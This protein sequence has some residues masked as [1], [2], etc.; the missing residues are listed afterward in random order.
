MEKYPKLVHYFKSHFNARLV[1]LLLINGIVPVLLISLTTY[2]FWFRTM[3]SKELTFTYSRIS[4]IN[5]ALDSLTTDI[6]QNITH[7][8]SNENIRSY[9]K[10]NYDEVTVEG[11]KKHMLIENFL[12]SIS[13]YGEVA[14]SYTLID[15]YDRIYTNGSN[16]NRLQNF[17]GPRL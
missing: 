15:R 1:L 4:T 8:F 6:E 12:K 5:Q 9:L 10:D 2:P 13:N 3:R 7:I 17:D 11:H 14:C 16:V